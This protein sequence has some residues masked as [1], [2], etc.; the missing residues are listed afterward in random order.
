MQRIWPKP[1]R[2]LITPIFFEFFGLQILQYYPLQPMA[3]TQP[4][5]STKTLHDIPELEGWRAGF[6][7]WETFENYF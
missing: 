2:Y 7:D 4:V 5:L 6:G 3:I 1:V